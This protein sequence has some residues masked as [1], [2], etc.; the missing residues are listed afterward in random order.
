MTINLASK[1]DNYPIPKEN[2]LFTKLVGG[3]K[4]T[5]LDLSQAYQQMR[6]SDESKKYLTVNTTK[7]LFQPTRLPYG[8]KS[9]PG[10]F[11]RE[12]ENRLPRV[13]GT[14]V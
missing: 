6:L 11:Q 7:G 3:Q 8:V 13:P 14:V 12:I 4:F 9:A 5:K 1:L 2:D 10:I